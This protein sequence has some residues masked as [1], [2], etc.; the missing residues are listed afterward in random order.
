MEKAKSPRQGEL[1][2]IKTLEDGAW[3]ARTVTALYSKSAE[4]VA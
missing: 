3:D 4:S 2:I 1:G